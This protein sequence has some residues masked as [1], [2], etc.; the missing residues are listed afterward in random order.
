M[1]IQGR[2]ARPAGTG[3]MYKDPGYD[4]VVNKMNQEERGLRR[5]ASVGVLVIAAHL[6]HGQKAACLRCCL[7]KR[8]EAK[9]KCTTEE[10]LWGTPAG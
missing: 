6:R 7:V 9:S 10:K 1:I 4:D 3:A 8:Y 5:R 2:N